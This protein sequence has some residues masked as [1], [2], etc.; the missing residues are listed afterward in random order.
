MD[1]WGGGAGIGSSL[2]TFDLK[3]FMIKTCSHPCHTLSISAWKGTMDWFMPVLFVHWAVSYLLHKWVQALFVMDWPSTTWSPAGD[4]EEGW[5]EIGL[6]QLFSCWDEV[7]LQIWTHWL[8][9]SQAVGLERG[10]LNMVFAVYAGDLGQNPKN[11]QQMFNQL[12]RQWAAQG[13]RGERKRGIT[14]ATA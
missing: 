9:I 12:S 1:V 14:A 8:H 3:L 13:A 5:R 2:M 7:F 6:R 4:L 11:G 10:T